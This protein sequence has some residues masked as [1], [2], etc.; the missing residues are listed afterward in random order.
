MNY[1]DQTRSQTILNEFV[2]VDSF[3]NV[4]AYMKGTNEKWTKSQP[5]CYNLINVTPVNVAILKRPYPAQKSFDYRFVF[6]L[7]LNFFNES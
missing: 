4:T 7:K 6:H 2:L 1:L 3:V 5:I